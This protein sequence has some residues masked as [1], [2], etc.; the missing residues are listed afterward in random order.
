MAFNEDI[1]ERIIQN[2]DLVDLIGEIVDL[3]KKGSNY[4]G[5]CPFHN[6]KTP[7]F[8]VSPEKGIYK[9][10]GC[11][12][13]GNSITFMTDYH[14]L[15]FPEA[16]TE[17]GRR[18]GI[19]VEEKTTKK[20]KEQLNQQDLALLALDAS[21]EFYCRQLGQKSGKIASAYYHKRNFAPDTIAAF[22]LGYAPDSWDSLLT[23]LKK[24]KFNEKVLTDAGLI[25]KNESKD[26]YY[27]R[28]RNRAIFPIQNFMGK[29]IGFGARQLG[30]E[31]DQPKYINSPQSLVYDKSQTLYGIFHAKNEIRSKQSV[32]LVE[33][34]VD[35]ITSWQAGFKNIVASSGTSLTNEQLNILGKLCKRIYFVYDADN[36]GIHATERGVEMALEKGFDVLIVSLPSGE[37]P[38]S[39]IN[40]HGASVFKSYINDAKSFI[41]YMVG[42]MKEEGKFDNPS[43]KAQSIRQILT[44]I[45]K[46]P[47]R[48]QHDEYISKMADLINLTESQKLQIYDEKRKLESKQVSSK[49]STSKRLG[50]SEVDGQKSN[51][52]SDKTSNENIESKM[53]KEEQ[54]LLSLA[55]RGDDYFDLIINKIKVNQEHLVTEEAKKFFNYF[56]S[57]NSKAKNFLNLLFSKREIPEADLDFLTLLAFRGEEL[58]ENWARFLRIPQSTDYPRIIKDLVYQLELIKLENRLMEIK[59]NFNEKSDDEQFESMKMIAEINAR[60]SKIVKEIKSEKLNK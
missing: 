8:M 2:T 23:E 27:D 47:D 25:I 3:R 17:L 15:S 16:L 26:S 9:C 22:S 10:F 56:V 59:K 29:V 57:V 46:I 19:Q 11:G 37:D 39:L 52:I 55:L 31:R 14:G 35:V 54:M 33:G 20:V 28:F 38:D 49:S 13:S 42:K 41:E 51:V 44:I 43:E 21:K 50:D 4:S 18:A 45:T 34:Y 53:L 1:K 6:E 40:N 60:K 24:Q 7:S 48:L 58:S 12:K 36:A 32:I 30:E 5:L